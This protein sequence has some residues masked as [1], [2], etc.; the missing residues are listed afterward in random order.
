MKKHIL[1][2][3]LII[4]TL[5]A[6]ALMFLSACGGEKESESTPP[7]ET[8]NES[9]KKDGSLS[10]SLNSNKSDSFNPYQT[11]TQENMLVAQLMY[12]NIFEVDENYNLTSNVITEKESRDNM[13]IF[14]VDTSIIMHD[15]SNLSAKDLVYSLSQAFGS[16]RFRGRFNTYQGAMASGDDTLIISTKKTN[17]MLPYILNVPII[18]AGQGKETAPVGCGPY[19]LSEDGNSLVAFDEYK[20]RDSLPFE[21]IELKE[22]V[23]IEERIDAFEDGEVNLVVNDR[24]GKNSLGYGGKNEIRYFTTMNLHYFGF[25]MT[26][27]FV[28]KPGVRYAMQFALNREE[29]AKVFLN[30]NALPTVAAVH[31]RSE[32]YNKNLARSVNFNMENCLVSLANA[33]V[34][35]GDNDGKLENMMYGIP[36]EI[37]VDLIVCADGAGKGDIARKFAKELSNIGVTVSVRELSWQDYVTA[38]K[39]G[40]FDMYYAEVK[41]PGDFNIQNMFEEEGSLNY[42]NIKDDELLL[43]IDEFLAA[44]DDTRADKCYNMMNVFI[45]K[46]PIIPICFE[47]RELIMQRN[48][49][50]GVDPCS[51]NVFLGIANWRVHNR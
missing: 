1:L 22:F 7:P 40:E 43:V 48:A 11:K 10:F 20:Q 49:V 34:I 30:N 23:T 50:T 42:G 8:E 51:G 2:I 39:E 17:K 45:N 46:S 47:R 19:M 21:I 33:G 14:K 32:L 44:G 35:D 28:A 12:E 3:I 27:D 25:N 5:S 38:L 6:L 4:I 41:I 15:G 26:D 31:P 13:W 29:A 18:K 36:V 16:T 37:N 24:T 9:G